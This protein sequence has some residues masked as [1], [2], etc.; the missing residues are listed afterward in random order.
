MRAETD[1]PR[2]TLPGTCTAGVA[3]YTPRRW[4]C[5][6]GSSALRP[7]RAPRSDMP[8]T[9]GAD[10]AMSMRFNGTGCARFTGPLP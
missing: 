4:P 3:G 10:D 2:I 9:I 7:L 1:C 8:A 6:R 5:G